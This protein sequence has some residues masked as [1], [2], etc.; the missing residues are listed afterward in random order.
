MCAVG[1]TKI[2]GILKKNK[3]LIGLFNNLVTKYILNSVTIRSS[4]TMNDSEVIYNLLFALIT[5][6]II[7]PPLEFVEIGL[8]INKLFKNLLGNED[9][10][11]IQYHQRRCT[12][13]LVVHCFLPFTYTVLYY[14]NFDNV[15]MDDKDNPIMYMMWNSFFITSLAMPLL[16]LGV[17]FLWYRNDYTNHPITKTLRKYC[18]NDNNWHSVA[19]SINDEYRR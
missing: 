14:L 15:W 10:E 19:T 17:G 12:L 2:F 6:C 5:Y 8:T 13:T 4:P 1:H 7:Y 9:I 18:N 16:G 3:Q 11:F